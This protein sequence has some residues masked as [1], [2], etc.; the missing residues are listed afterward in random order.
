MLVN[1]DNSSAIKA[2]Q[3][4]DAN[5]SY[6]FS[7][8]EKGKYIIIFNYDTRYLFSNRISEKWGIK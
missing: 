7:G 3:V 5:G 6:K 1:T 8:L 4:T 2:K